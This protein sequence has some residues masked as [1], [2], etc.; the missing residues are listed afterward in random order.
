MEHTPRWIQIITLIYI[1]LNPIMFILGAVLGQRTG[2][3][4]KSKN[5]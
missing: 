2:Q 3:N 1:A 4:R 5:Q